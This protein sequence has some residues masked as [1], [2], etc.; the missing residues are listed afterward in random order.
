MTRVKRGVIKNKRRHNIL[1]QTKGF[2]FGR[3]TKVAQAK[4]ALFHAGTYSFAH[5]KDKKSD[6]RS[7]WTTRINAAT[8]PLGVSYSR[9]IDSLKKKNIKI[10]RKIL[11]DIA[12]NNPE[13][14]ARIIKSI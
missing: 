9:F 12:E 8:R 5:R 10:D 2:R 11:S 7:L 13:T 14:F 6:A 3:S 4:E 1:S